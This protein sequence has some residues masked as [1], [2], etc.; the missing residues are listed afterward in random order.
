MVTLEDKPPPAGFKGI[1]AL[2]TVCGH[3]MRRV[4]TL[5]MGLRAL[6]TMEKVNLVTRLLS[7]MGRVAFTSV[8]R[9]SGEASSMSTYLL[10]N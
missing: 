8:T 5:T 1:V 7:V 4:P 2:D 10:L 6:S 9:T 3:H